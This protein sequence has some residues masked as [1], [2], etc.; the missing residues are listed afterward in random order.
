MLPAERVTLRLSWMAATRLSL[1]ATRCH[2]A[3]GTQHVQVAAMGPKEDVQFPASARVS[4][5]MPAQTTVN[6]ETVCKK[7]VEGTEVGIPNSAMITALRKL[8]TSRQQDPRLMECFAHSILW[9][10]RRM[11]LANLCIV[12]GL[13]V[14]YQTQKG[15]ELEQ[16]VVDQLR[17]VVRERLSEAESV[18]DIVWLLETVEH[19]GAAEHKRRFVLEVQD[20]A[21]QL[22]GSLPRSDV[23]LLVRT[24]ARLKL[25]PTPLLQAAAFYLSKG[26][27]DASMK[28][29]VSLLHA[30]HSLSFPEPSV[31]QQLSG[32]FVE[33]LADDTKVSLVAACFTGVGQLSWRH[34]ELLESCSSWIVTHRAS[35]RPADFTACLLSLARLQY[36]PECSEQVFPVLLEELSEG[37][38]TTMPAVW[39]DIV[40]SLASLG[41]AQQTH[42]DS[43]LQHHFYTPL[44]EDSSLAVP[45]RQKLLNIIAVNDLEFPDG[46]SFPKEMVESIVEN[47]KVPEAGA[48][49]RSVREA[50]TQLAPLGRYLS[51]SPSL[52]YGLTADGEMIVDKN[53]QPVLLDSKPQ[54]DHHRIALVVLDYRDFTLHSQVPTGANALRM[55]LL[56]HLGY[57]VLQV[58]YTEYDEKKPVLQRVRYLHEKLLQC[59]ARS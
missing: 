17:T 10:S 32:A 21:L 14:K 56:K 30:L 41:K 29:I 38:F 20:R 16:R 44:L 2:A 39:L 35:C 7:V 49:Q 1:A 43:V 19:M 24:L 40:W 42:L 46:P 15:S 11:D 50:L 51:Q 4:E 25:R 47:H 58:P 55:R 3:L 12:L 23:R 52:P 18:R 6:F 45:S 5:P 59:V 31:L 48:L 54:P 26:P 28:E 34:T 37:H 57:K 33:Q 36:M 27:E 13:H 53:A 22:V 9:R 8:L